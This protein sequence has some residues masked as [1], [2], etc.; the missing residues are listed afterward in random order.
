MIHVRINRNPTN[1]F[2]GSFSI[3]G[4]ANYAELGQD[5]VCAGV[6]AITVG[7]VNAVEELLGVVLTHRMKGGFLQAEVPDVLHEDKVDQLQ[8]L[9]ESMVVML[10]S[11]EETYGSYIKVK[12]SEQKRR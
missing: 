8:L 11:I 2:I 6:S 3:T 9:L 1:G 12:Q 4:H 5:I 7:T 10:E